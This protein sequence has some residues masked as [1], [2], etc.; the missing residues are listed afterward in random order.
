MN[1]HPMFVHFPIALL[2][3]YAIFEI[4]WSP[5]LRNSKTWFFIKSIFLALGFA[6]AQVALQTGE[7]AE[8]IVGQSKLIETHSNFA[9]ITT[10]LFG[11]ILLAYFIKVIKMGI[12]PNLTS[13][14]LKENFWGKVYKI[15]LKYKKIVLETPLIYLLALAGLISITL[16]GALGGAIVYG[17]NADP[18]VSFIYKLL[19][20]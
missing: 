19:I 5:R 4:V 2:T 14:F 3:I 12:L 1:I 8:E 18:F 11:A 9:N 13:I 7:M 20:K 16:T 6:G 17:T 10:Y 15:L